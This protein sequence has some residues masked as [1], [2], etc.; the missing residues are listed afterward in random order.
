MNVTSCSYDQN[1]MTR[2]I[3]NSLTHTQWQ[4]CKVWRNFF[5]KEKHNCFFFYYSTKKVMQSHAYF[6]FG[7]FF[8][9]AVEILTTCKIVSI[10]HWNW[11][12]IDIVSK[13]NEWWSDCDTMMFVAWTVF[14]EVFPNVFFLLMLLFSS[15][16]TAQKF[17]VN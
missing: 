7:L 16:S 14:V 11:L 15:S 10:A 3:D 2:T 1:Y 5:W 17:K 13:L 6:M 4:V 9:W 8:D 12:P